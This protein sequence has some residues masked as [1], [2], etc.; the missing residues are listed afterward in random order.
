MAT[1]IDR[2]LRRMA[3][4]R[5][6]V[7]RAAGERARLSVF[8][9]SKH[10]YA[11]VIDDAKGQTLASAS[12]LEKDMRDSLKTGARIANQ[13]GDLM[14]KGEMLRKLADLGV[15]MPELQQKA[16]PAQ[17]LG[18]GQIQCHRCGLIKP[19]MAWPMHYASNPFLKG[20]PAEYKAALG[21]SSVQ[22]IDAEPGTKKTF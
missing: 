3:K 22:V 1:V 18:E 2:T 16:A 17:Q 11:Q 5:R 12:S 19:K 8:R 14:P 21:P 7:R 10:I 15:E 13:R 9:S 4:V 20:T 6:N